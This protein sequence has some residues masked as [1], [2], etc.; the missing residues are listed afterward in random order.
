MICFFDKER[1]TFCEE[2]PLV[3]GSAVAATLLLSMVPAM[4]QASEAIRPGTNYSTARRQLLS[5]G[6]IPVGFPKKRCLENVS[7]RNR[8]CEVY[9]ETDFC[10]GTGMAN[11]RFVFQS[12]RGTFLVVT[13]AG[14]EQDIPGREIGRDLGVK[15]ARVATKVESAEFMPFALREPIQPNGTRHSSN[16]ARVR[17]EVPVQIPSYPDRDACGSNGV[18]TGLDPN[19]DGFLAVKSGPGGRYQRIDKLFNGEQVYLCAEVGDW[20]GIVYSKERQDCNVMTSWPKSLPYTGP[21]RS[22]WVHK[23]WV[24]G[25]AG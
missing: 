5:K 12:D 14:E 25:F 11:C 7:G 22:G 19:G 8:I 9:Q 3:A 6:Y 13:T 20:L 24:E 21:C 15:S 2:R 4:A 18:V 16:E 23:H 1:G 17:P 10:A